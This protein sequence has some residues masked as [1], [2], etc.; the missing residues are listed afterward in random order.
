MFGVMDFAMWISQVV[1]N[2][3]AFSSCHLIKYAN[4]WLFGSGGKFGS[5]GGEG[6]GVFSL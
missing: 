1:V 5:G 3:L 6:I 2:F 4:T